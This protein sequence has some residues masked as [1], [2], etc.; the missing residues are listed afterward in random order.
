MPRPL[1]FNFQVF[2]LGTHVFPD[3]SFSL[4]LLPEIGSSIMH[5]LSAEPVTMIASTMINLCAAY[6][7]KFLRVTA[8]LFMYWGLLPLDLRCILENYEVTS[9]AASC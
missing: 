4:R 5:W 3:H 6:G 8:S 1:N 7:L 2:F 9:P